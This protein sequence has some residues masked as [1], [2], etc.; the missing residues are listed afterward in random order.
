[1]IEIVPPEHPCGTTTEHMYSNG[2]KCRY[3]GGRGWFYKDNENKESE[4]VSCPL[5]DGTGEMDAIIHVVWQ[6]T[7]K[8]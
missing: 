6:P 8:K 3:C 1:M 2:H 4:T 7:R 5:C